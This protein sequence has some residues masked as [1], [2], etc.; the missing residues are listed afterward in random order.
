MKKLIGTVAVAALLATAAFAEGLTFGSWGRALWIV[1]NAGTANTA[2]DATTMNNNTVTSWLGQSWGGAGPR[3]GVAV[4]GSSDNIGFDLD[5]H[6]N[7]GGLGVGDNALVWAK[8]IDMLKIT[9]AAKNDQNVLRGDATFG[10]WN[11]DRIGAVAE[12][13]EEGWIFPAILNKNVSIVATPI[14]GLTVGYGFNCFVADT[15]WGAASRKAK[16]GF[17][18]HNSNNVAIDADSNSFACQIGRTSALAAAYKISN[19]G[20]VK[21]GFEAKGKGYDKN[22]GIDGERKDWF[23]IDAAFEFTMLE[24]V[25]IALGARIPMG[26]T[27][28]KYADIYGDGK[29]YVANEQATYV[30]LFSRLK[31]IDGL[32]INVLAGLKLNSKDIKKDSFKS[33]GAFGFRFGA[34]AEYSFSNG[35]GV[36]A[37][38]EYA[39]GIWMASNSADKNDTLT[40]GLG[41]TKGFSNGVIGVAFE[42]AT[43]A[44]GRNRL[45]NQDDLAWEIP[46]K[47]EYWF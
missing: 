41:A 16:D 29:L 45:Q 43:N 37:E 10:L 17:S 21:V 3:T 22:G 14:E 32:T 34:E 28:G 30:N 4:H 8:P 18:A 38:V 2:K 13:D 12:F 25:Y 11:M 31:L 6:A 26:G 9:F 46:L 47:I 36:F 42:G 20:T 5:L 40:F 1:G 15:G 19:I 33:S 39:N 27:F 7:G 24:K 23:Q 44:Y 35:L